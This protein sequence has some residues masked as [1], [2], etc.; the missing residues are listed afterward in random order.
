MTDSGIVNLF[1]TM[2]KILTDYVKIMPQ[3]F[4]KKHS[5]SNYAR[6]KPE[7]TAMHDGVVEIWP[8]NFDF[9]QS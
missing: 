4:S 6:S 7:F 8:T 3:N 2:L 5:K 9:S 1:W